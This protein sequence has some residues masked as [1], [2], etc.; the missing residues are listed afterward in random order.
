ML[1]YLSP[2]LAIFVFIV[3]I[4]PLKIN[5]W[6]KLIIFGILFCISQKYFILYL[7]GG[8]VFFAPR[9]PR[10]IM[11]F[12]AWI[13]AVLIA[14]FALLLVSVIARIIIHL[15]YRRKKKKCPQTGRR[16]FAKPISFCLES[17]FSVQRSAFTGGLLCRKYGNERSV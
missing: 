15:I 11:L 17:Q 5:R 4:F 2:I 13:Y 8:P 1:I 3:A 9:L 12:S 16:G 6:W 14:W 7:F 10:G